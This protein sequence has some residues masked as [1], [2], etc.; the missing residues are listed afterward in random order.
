VVKLSAQLHRR[1]YSKDIPGVNKC[2]VIIVF[3]EILRNA[4]TGP[5][6]QIQID[7][8]KLQIFEGRVDALLDAF[9]PWVVELCGDPDLAPW[10]TGVLDALANLFFVAI[11]KC[12]W[13]VNGVFFSC[14]WTVS[15]VSMCR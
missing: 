4:G 14:P 12:T 9:V 2:P 15:H 13:Y 11:C 10:D 5:V 3:G 7:I 6:H 1:N 8:I